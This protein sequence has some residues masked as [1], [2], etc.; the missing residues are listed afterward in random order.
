RFAWCDDVTRCK[1]LRFEGTEETIRRLLPSLVS[2]LDQDLPHGPSR[3]PGRSSLIQKL[4]RRKTACHLPRLQNRSPLLHTPTAF[5]VAKLR[6]RIRRSLAS[7]AGC[8]G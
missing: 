3:G 2:Y 6:G 7:A 4:E 5:P 1:K 8:A